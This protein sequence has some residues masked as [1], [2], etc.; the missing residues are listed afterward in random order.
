MSVSAT[1]SHTANINPPDSI[2]R[3][4]T[5]YYYENAYVLGFKLF[6]EKDTNLL[7]IG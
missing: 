6:D 5:I 7:S 4:I 2:V 3:K 1:F